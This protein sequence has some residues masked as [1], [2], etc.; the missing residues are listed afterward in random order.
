M[1]NKTS[2]L[3]ICLLAISSAVG[4]TEPDS[5]EK[6]RRFLGISFPSSKPA[7]AP[8]APATPAVAVLPTLPPNPPVNYSAL[9]AYFTEDAKYQSNNDLL[10]ILNLF[11][12]RKTVEAI[13]NEFWHNAPTVETCVSCN[14]LIRHM[15]YEY[16]GN[17]AGF[18][19][20][21]YS[22]CELLKLDGE[23][24]QEFCT[25]LTEI[26]A[27]QLF[28]ILENTKLNSEEICASLL[29]ECLDHYHWYGPPLFWEVKISEKIDYVTNATS[30]IKEYMA[31]RDATD[32]STQNAKK[33]PPPTETKPYVA[34][35]PAT[36]NEN[37]YPVGKP[38]YEGTFEG[39]RFLHLTDLHLDLLYSLHS[40]GYCDR[41]LCCRR[42]EPPV[43]Y[44]PA[45]EASYPPAT[46]AS[47]PPVAEPAT[48]ASPVYPPGNKPVPRMAD[49]NPSYLANL[50][51]ANQTYA[52]S[53]ALKKPAGYWGSFGKC[54]SP[55]R[56]IKHMLRH[57]SK[58]VDQID[59]VVFSGDSISHNI[60]STNK[61]Q[62]IRTNEILIKLITKYLLTPSAAKPGAYGNPSAYQPRR[63]VPVI[64]NH[65][66]DVVSM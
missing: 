64:G 20:F 18:K 33:S 19:K 11:T 10:Q 37:N 21:F 63:L 12:T 52:Y 50:Y 38:Y 55:L 27:P 5:N 47:Y 53:N 29:T 41:I 16:K 23:A 25:G 1:V 24:N 30:K 65:E 26:Y 60:W 54:D 46:E 49:P 7:S 14:V 39:A 15:I 42:P 57:L 66:S 51:S 22:V 59:Y 17:E 36:Y 45:A 8:E 48:T 58:F 32:E 62:V 6:N 61:E 40:D 28:Y 43:S 34:S 9:P 56:L 2:F 35:P 44:P 31:P 4:Q 13:V 3:L